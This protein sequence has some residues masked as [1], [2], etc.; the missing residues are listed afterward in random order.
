ML[1]V[2]LPGSDLFDISAIQKIH[3]PKQKLMQ[4][5]EL[6]KYSWGAGTPKSRNKLWGAS[7]F[8]F[9]KLVNTPVNKVRFQINSKSK[10]ILLEPGSQD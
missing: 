1:S 7:P 5:C 8:R 10:Q 4:R 3:N 2:C 9:P 6:I